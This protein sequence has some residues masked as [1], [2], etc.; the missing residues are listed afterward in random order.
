MPLNKQTKQ[1][2]LVGGGAL[3]LVLVYR[4]VHGGGGGK[5]PVPVTSGSGGQIAPYTPQS[6]VTLDPGQ[7]VYDPNSEGLINTPTAPSAGGLISPPAPPQSAIPGNPGYT[8][9][10]TYP[11]ITTKT[12]ATRK[13]AVR[14]KYAPKTAKRT[15]AK[16]PAPGWRGIGGGWWAPPRTT[17]AK[18]KTRGGT[19][20]VRAKVKK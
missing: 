2:L 4:K 6:P 10:V 1:G 19:T 11:P 5:G 20:A 17:V 7:S 16:P 12:P 8:V 18:P 9:N 15:G 3:G 14:P 13:P